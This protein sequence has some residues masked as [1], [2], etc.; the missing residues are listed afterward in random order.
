MASR[1]CER[2]GHKY[3][4]VVSDPT[5][6]PPPDPAEWLTDLLYTGVG[7]GILAINRAQAARRD[8]EAAVASSDEPNPTAEVLRSLLDNPAVTGMQEL[9]S[10]PERTRNLADRL[11]TEMQ[12]LDD[13]LDGFENRLAAMLDNIETELPPGAQDATKALRALATEH[14]AQ[15]RAILG[16]KAR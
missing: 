16:L 10:D 1:W 6:A 3:S 4:E 15:M 14:A 9:L 12:D 2:A 8:L 7:L 11:R 5:D 13:R